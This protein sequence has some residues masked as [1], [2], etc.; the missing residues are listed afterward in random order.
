[1]SVLI[2]Q[3]LKSSPESFKSGETATLQLGLQSQSPAGE[4][5]IVE[6]RLSPGND[7]V[8]AENGNKFITE[9]FTVSSAPTAVSRAYALTSTG[10][11]V[12][13]IT[14]I[15]LPERLEKSKEAVTILKP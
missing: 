7:V 1:M 12:V 5:S 8:F 13:T 3:G 15:V 14:A 9:T 4:Q 6:Y 11:K 2:V 10:G